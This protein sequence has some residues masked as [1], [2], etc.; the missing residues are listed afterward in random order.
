MLLDELASQLDSVVLMPQFLQFL[1]P[2]LALYLLV[3]RL[4]C[5]LIHAD[6]LGADDLV[7]LISGQL[8]YQVP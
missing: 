2:L 6:D 7:D 5:L 3:N 4:A 8:I 1:T